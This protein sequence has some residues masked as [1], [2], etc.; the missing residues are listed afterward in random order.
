MIEHLPPGPWSYETNAAV[1]AHDGTGFVYILDGNGRKI[2]TCWG[3]PDEKLATARLII[4]ARD[5]AD[6]SEG[7]A[8]IA[9]DV[10]P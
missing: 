6:T 5:W 10:V 4:R 2:G 7:A 8:E 1:G 9:K 3:R